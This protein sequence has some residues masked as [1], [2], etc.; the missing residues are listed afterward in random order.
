MLNVASIT[1]AKVV[2]QSEQGMSSGSTDRRVRSLSPSCAP[3]V[4][5]EDPMLSRY[6]SKTTYIDGDIVQ[7]GSIWRSS[8]TADGESFCVCAWLVRSFARSLVEGTPDIH[9]RFFSGLRMLTEKYMNWP[10]EEGAATANARF[11]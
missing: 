2:P 11:E 3:L 5:L 10:K 9:L 6:A 8:R 4:S 1:V 7:L